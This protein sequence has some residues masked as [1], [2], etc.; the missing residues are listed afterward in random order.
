MSILGNICFHTQLS[1]L[2]TV[3]KTS[4]MEFDS[5]STDRALGGQANQTFIFE[6]G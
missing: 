5:F 1:S 4:Y 6:P 3:S 2:M